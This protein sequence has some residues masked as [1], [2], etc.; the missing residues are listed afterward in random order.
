MGDTCLKTVPNCGDFKSSTGTCLSCL[1]GFTLNGNKCEQQVSNPLNCPL[2][3]TNTNGICTVIDQ[4]CIFYNPDNTCMLCAKG[5]QIVAGRCSKIICKDRQY[6]GSGSCVDVSPLCDTFDLI[7]GNCLTCV[8]SYYLQADGSC[9]QVLTSQLGSNK[10]KPSSSNSDCADGYYLRQGTCVQ[11]SPTCGTYDS[12]TGQCTTCISSSYYLNETNGACVLISSICG[13]RTYFSNG[14]CLPV[15]NLCDQF[16]TT[17]GNCLTCRDGSTFSK[18]NC[19]FLVSCGERMYHAA[20]GSC[21]K[22]SDKCDDYDNNSGACLSCISG[23]ELNTGGICCY[24][25]NY[26]ID[27]ACTQ[28]YKPN[29]LAQR[30]QF[31]YCTKCAQGYALTNGVFG[32]CNLVPTN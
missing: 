14:D 11:V 16:D 17:N 10:A 13:Y 26:M 12:N 6:S 21:A 32:R 24:A 28:F 3:Q 22:V 19:V 25:Y 4:F 29:C 23:Y 2:G 9:L 20:D 27:P 15:S 8:F 30:Q 31:K 1:S 7:Y 18:G 5:Y